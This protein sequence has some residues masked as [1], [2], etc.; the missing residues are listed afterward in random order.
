MSLE[1]RSPLSPLGLEGLAICKHSKGMCVRLCRKCRGL[2]PSIVRKG[3]G[4]VKK[5]LLE[6]IMTL[7][8][9]ERRAFRQIFFKNM[10]AR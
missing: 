1:L 5:E 7:S 2:R 10:F 3:R 4:L 6:I 9:R 8:K